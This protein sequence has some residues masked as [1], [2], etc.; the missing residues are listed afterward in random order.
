M[1]SR[2]ARASKDIK[3]NPLAAATDPVGGIHDSVPISPDS[4]HSASR[5]MWQDQIHKKR[6][7]KKPPPG[8]SKHVPPVSDHQIDE[9]AGAC[10]QGGCEV[11][12]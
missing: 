7:P 6:P 2:F 1:Q 12:S 8:N 4:D 10:S 3:P 9:Y 5:D 11:V